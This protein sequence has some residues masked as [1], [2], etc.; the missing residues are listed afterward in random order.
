M[1]GA[2][3]ATLDILLTWLNGCMLRVF[4]TVLTLFGIV[5]STF[6]LLHFVRLGRYS[7]RIYTLQAAQLILRTHHNRLVYVP[8]A[9]GAICYITLMRHK[10]R[11]IL[12]LRS[13]LGLVIQ[14]YTIIAL[15]SL[16][17][18]TVGLLRMRGARHASW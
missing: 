12:Y 10:Y 6:E 8:I 16:A 14:L 2:C 7:L 18:I 1:V 13:A 11:I 3:S 4:L 17:Y 9:R 5:T 15:D